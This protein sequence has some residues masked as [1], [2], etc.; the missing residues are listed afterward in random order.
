MSL[1]NPRE[2]S[3]SG[4]VRTGRSEQGLKSTIRP[5][6]ERVS[7]TSE[8]SEKQL[9]FPVWVQCNIILDELT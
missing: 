3:D 2:L 6:T 8:L 7:G 9:S 4:R 5:R 1:L